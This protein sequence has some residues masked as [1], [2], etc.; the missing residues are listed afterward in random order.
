MLRAT[1]ETVADITDA[2]VLLGSPDTSVNGLAVDSREVEP[3][4]V[5]AALPGEATDGHV[6]IEEALRGGARLILVTRGAEELA[7]AVLLA[8]QR[9]AS[10]LQVADALAAVQALATWHRSRLRC[11]VIGVTG[12]SGKTTTKD[13]LTSVLA[14]SMRVAS[15]VGNRNN[16]LGVPLTVFSAGSETDALIVEMGM[17]GLGQISQLCSIARPHFGLVTNV[18]TSHIELLGSQEAVAAAKAELVSCVPADG[19]VFLNGDDCYSSVLADSAVAPVTYYGLGE[20]CTVRAENVE[21]DEE[22]RASFDL[23]TSQGEV[24]VRLPVPGRHNVYNALAAASV[25]LR[26]AVTL[27]KVSEGLAG[28]STQAMR[29]ESFTAASGVLVINDAYNANPSSMAA[30]VDTLAQVKVAGRRVAVLGDMA[31]LGSLTELAHFRIGEQ[32]AGLPIDA[33]VTVGAKARRIADGAKAKGMAADAVRPCQTVDEAVEVLDDLLVPGD[34][35]LVKASR[36]MGLEAV[37]DGIV[38]PR[39][40]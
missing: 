6:F 29:M 31:E 14:T 36:V 22:S 16:E 2:Q 3:G 20:T 1:V 7:D 8:S 9:G 5:F 34:A 40:G 38:T 10:V 13:F 12:S 21:L 39:A 15:T 18:G 37:V 28:A 25:G 32:V 23:I 30:A 24:A 26:L 35:V 4:C 19:S 27:E 17:R 33:L 11:A